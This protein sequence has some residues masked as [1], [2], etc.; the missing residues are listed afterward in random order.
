MAVTPGGR[1][2]AT[3]YAGPTPGEDQ[4]NY[5]VLST[6]ADNGRTWTETLV[7]DP[8]EDGPVRAFDPELWLAPD[9][10]LFV[11]WAQSIGHN[12]K[13]SGVWSLKISSPEEAAPQ[14]GQPERWTD[15]VMMC[16]PLVLSTGEWVLP[17]STWA[18]TDH[19]AKMAVSTDRGKT[20]TVRGGCN[21]PKEVRSADEHMFVERNDGSLWLLARTRYGIGESVSTDRGKTWPELKPSAIPHTVARFFVRRL[22]SGNLLLVKHGPMDQ[23]TG[24]S[25]LTAFISTDDGK[26]WGGGLLLDERS[27]VSYPDGQ[28]TADGLIR[29]IYD[30]SRTGARHILMAAFREEDAAAGK[31]VSGAVNLRQLVSEGSGGREKKAEP[32]RDN[33]DGEALRKQTPGS[34]HANG[35]KTKDVSNGDGPLKDAAY[36]W[37]MSDG[38]N[39]TGSAGSLK[40]SGAVQFSVALEESERVA[41]LARGGDGKV[42]RFEGGYLALSNDAELKINPKHWTVAIRMRDPAGTWRYPILGSYGSDQQVSFA[43]RAVDGSNKPFTDRNRGGGE[44]PTI[45]S[46]MFR[47]G[48]P[49]PVAGSP[50]LS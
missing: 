13:I 24:R 12:G 27:G 8:D 14:Y 28:Q 46:W 29:I 20:W 4:N 39:A 2:W 15:G 36:L 22:D 25:H 47:P 41:S 40:S 10:N 44:V 43:L 45:Y 49:R 33:A 19:S 23:R 50:S 34:L 17:A 6:S 9:G 48:G 38:S 42:A 30:F 1:L 31:D 18:S 32:V 7:V 3:W 5:V 37:Q 11:I 21:V 16:K 35:F 26:T